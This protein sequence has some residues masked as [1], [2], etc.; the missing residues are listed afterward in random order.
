MAEEC[1][2]VERGADGCGQERRT[3]V[4]VRSVSVMLLLGRV[5]SIVTVLLLN[6]TLFGS[7]AGWNGSRLLTRL[8]RPGHLVVRLVMLL[9]GWFS[10]I[11]A[12]V[13]MCVILGAN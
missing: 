6:G 11:D 12:W 7:A 4:T 2:S 13:P 5:L 3:A 8:I 10:V 1:P 9:S